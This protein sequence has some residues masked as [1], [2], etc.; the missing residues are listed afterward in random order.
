VTGLGHVPQDEIDVWEQCLHV[1]LPINHNDSGDTPRV[2]GSASGSARSFDGIVFLDADNWFDPSHIEMLIMAHRVSG[3]AVITC[4]RRLVRP[5]NGEVLGT[6]TESDGRW[7]ND[8]NCYLITQGAYP[9]LAAWGFR[10]HAVKEKVGVVGDRLFWNAI[11][12][13]G[14]KRVHMPEPTVNYETA[15]AVHY[16]ARKLDIPAFA[17][18]I[19]W[20]EAEQAHRL[21]SYPIYR[22]LVVQGKVKDFSG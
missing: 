15:Y 13:S 8:T 2:I 22:E 6:C 5:D 16:H 7:F 9:L 4:A 19:V 1:R 11:V 12:K 10:G 20:L 3:A 21:V 17:K 18:V 14:I